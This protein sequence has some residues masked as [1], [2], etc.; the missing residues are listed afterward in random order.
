MK[1]AESAIHAYRT[2]CT[3]KD[4]PGRMSALFFTS[5]CNFRCGFCHNPDLFNSGKNYSWEE[6]DA[7]CA[8]FRKQWISAVVISGGE[9]TIHESLPDTVQ[10]FKNRGFSVKLDTN[11]SNPEMLRAILPQLDYVAMDL[12][13]ALHNYPGLTGYEDIGKIRESIGIIIGGAK[14]YE[15]RTTV[16]ETIHTDD[17]MSDCGK[18]LL[19]A[20]RYILQPFVPHDDLLWPSLRMQPRTRPSFLEHA[21]DVAS[22]FVDKVEIRGEM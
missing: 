20:K 10:F 21:A 3:M 17:E 12:K 1:S 4:Y 7:I 15:F 18:V 14:D 13:C 16:I 8:S 2:Q 6:L 11:G 19:G 9:P 5:G 22:G